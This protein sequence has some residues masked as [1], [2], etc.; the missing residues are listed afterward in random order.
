MIDL[1]TVDSDTHDLIGYLPRLTELLHEPTLTRSDGSTHR[2]ISGSPA[3]W[4]AEPAAILTDIHAGARDLEQSLS[5]LARQHRYLR[6]GADQVTV[7]ALRRVAALIRLTA[8]YGYRLSA[9]AA[10]ALSHWA[11]A[12]RR[13]LDE[14]RRGEEPPT[15][16]P[17]GLRCPTILDSGQ[18]CDRPLLLPPGAAN[19]RAP[20]VYCPA[21]RDDEGHP[22]S[23]PWDVWV[24]VVNTPDTP[25]DHCA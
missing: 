17:G 6:G 22:V 25:R 13:V 19:L 20:A 2:K 3:P 14:Q 8:P 18:Y 12:C 1:D 5:L 7:T 15:R 11:R 10:R 9:D 23:F 16:A 24:A 4:N 21:C